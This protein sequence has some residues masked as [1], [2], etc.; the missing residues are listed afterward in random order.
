MVDTFKSAMPVVISLRNE[1]L[2]LEHWKEIKELIGYDFDIEDENFTLESLIKLNA[3]QFQEEIQGISAQATAEASLRAQMQIIEDT[4]KKV[5]FKSKVY[6]EGSK[7]N[8]H[9]LE[10]VDDIYTSLDESMAAVNTILGNRFVKPLR[11]D[12]EVW[13]KNL[14]LLSKVLDNWVFL[15]KQW[16]YLENI[17]TTGDIRKQLPNE[18][19]KFDHVDKQFKQ[20]MQRVH[21][22][23][24]VM[25]ILKNVANL[26]ENLILYNETLEDIQKQLEKYLET[27]RQAFPRFYFLS[28]DELLEILAKSNDLEVI[29]QNL[30]TCFDNI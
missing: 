26:N 8:S 25:R 6:K 11:A 5:D 23:P 3:Q 2:K 4:W 10:D 29:Q 22:T 24:N 30:R 28:N 21:K 27:K 12:A 7:D 16:M 19:Q 14:M 13:K 20:L 1:N 15:Q 17:F 9:I 18:A